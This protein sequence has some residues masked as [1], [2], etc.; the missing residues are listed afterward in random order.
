MNLTVKQLDMSDVM[1]AQLLGKKRNAHF[2]VI[3]KR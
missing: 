2:K 1:A 3:L